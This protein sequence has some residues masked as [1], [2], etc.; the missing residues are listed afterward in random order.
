MPHLKGAHCLLRPATAS[1][2]L[3]ALGIPTR[4]LG[5]HS[6]SSPAACKSAFTSAAAPIGSSLHSCLS[7]GQLTRL[8]P[9]ATRYPPSA[10]AVAD[11]KPAIQQARDVIVLVVGPYHDAAVSLDAQ[12]LLAPRALVSPAQ[13][14]GVPSPAHCVTLR[15]MR[16]QTRSW[17]ALR[18]RNC[19]SA[20][21][22]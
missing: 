17:P 6:L 9:S 12:R 3:C 22:P 13:R 8:F 15:Q 20:G 16:Q 19:V 7:V 18:G 21:P 14:L 2:G 10:L 4:A 5:S 1:S 11:S